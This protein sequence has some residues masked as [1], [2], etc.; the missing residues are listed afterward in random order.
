MA[1]TIYGAVLMFLSTT[2][3]TVEIQEAKC[4]IRVKGDTV[5]TQNFLLIC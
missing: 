3:N 4:K 1:E 5:F 2:N